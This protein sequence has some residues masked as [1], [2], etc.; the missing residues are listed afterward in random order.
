[1]LLESSFESMSPTSPIRHN[2]E[3]P[4]EGFVT[5]FA[6]HE[7]DLR[8]FIRSMLPSADD[9]DEVLQQTAIVAWRKYD[10]YDPTTPFIKWACVIARFEAL[11]H[12]RKAARDRLV[13]REDLMEL[14]AEEGEA[15]I[16]PRRA[17]Q[18]ALESC[19]ESI[20]ASHRRLLLQA[21][22]PE[23]RIQEVAKEAGFT[24]AAFYMRLKRLRRKL[25][26]CV[27]S[28]LKAPSSIA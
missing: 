15:E 7:P 1:M 11:A 9:A 18:E 22:S 4:Y 13:F 24:A 2:M 28:K 27:E 3:D 19:L 21:Y 5:R 26:L 25:L 12:R 23:T 14:M 17:E 16:D 8:R 6:H 20:P 10:Q